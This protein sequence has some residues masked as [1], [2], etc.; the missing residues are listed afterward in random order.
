[1]QTSHRLVVGGALIALAGIWS[2]VI[3]LSANAAADTTGIC[4]YTDA[5]R[6]SAI[7]KWGL[8]QM[9]HGAGTYSVDST[10]GDP[11]EGKYCMKYDYSI[12]NYWDGLTLGT[13]VTNATGMTG[14]QFAMKGTDEGVYVN[15]MLGSSNGNTSQNI[16]HTNLTADWTK[17][18]MGLDQ[19]VDG[20][21]SLGN[22]K[23][24]D[25]TKF[26][27]IRFDIYNGSTSGSGT[28]WIDDII[29]VDAVGAKIAIPFTQGPAVSKMS[30]R[31]LTNG[32]VEAAVYRLD[33]ALVSRQSVEAKAGMPLSL[34][35]VAGSALPKGSYIVAM[36]G[37]G[38]DLRSTL[39]K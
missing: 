6:Y 37:A 20:A 19:F 24:V 2:L 28:L 31:A 36:K 34:S 35:A 7:S 25:F 10:T 22:P 17:V 1:M 15:V 30:P 16:S 39:I 29:L 4:I 33:G 8:G 21:D 5:A 18:E 14:L 32:P 3:P 38:I 26:S 13:R 9:Q 11:Y 27:M 23:P 12:A